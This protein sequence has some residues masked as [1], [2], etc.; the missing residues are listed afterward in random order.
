MP[1]LPPPPN[2]LP[3][4]AGGFVA[5]SGL[6]HAKILTNCQKTQ[7]IYIWSISVPIII[8]DLSF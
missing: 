5:L 1:T 4:G 6:R 7:I 2:L 3:S 8:F